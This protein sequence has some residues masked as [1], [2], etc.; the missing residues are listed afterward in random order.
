MRR[1]YE[2]ELAGLRRELEEARRQNRPITLEPRAPQTPPDASDLPADAIM[3]A[4]VAPPPPIRPPARDEEPGTPPSV[5]ALRGGAEPTPEPE[6]PASASQPASLPELLEAVAPDDA[7][8][9]APAMVLVN[10]RL[11]TR[12]APRYPAAARRHN[13]GASVTVRVLVGPDG[14]VQDVERVGG[15]AG[16]G[17]DRAAEDAARASTWV[18]GSRNGEP[19]AMWAELRFE[20]KP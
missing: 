12:P 14:Q 5:A 10:P 19:S 7:G 15:R 2:Q 11:L 18:A 13:R 9:A 1:R 8:A 6:P 3:R 16:M 4:A 20:F 17:F